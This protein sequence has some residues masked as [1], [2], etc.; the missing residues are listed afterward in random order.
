VNT[1]S[2]TDPKR[3]VQHAPRAIKL[4]LDRE[5]RRLLDFH[6]GGGRWELIAAD[7]DVSYSW[8]SKFTRGEITNPGYATLRRLYLYLGN[9]STS[10][11][12]PPA[13]MT[14]PQSESA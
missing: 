6:R 12:A 11:P 13:S 8:I 2:D 5:V 14:S 10:T 9:R 1:S 4:E 7:T 3:S